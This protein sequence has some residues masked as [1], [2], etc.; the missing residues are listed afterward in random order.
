MIIPFGQWA[1]DLPIY[2]NDGLVELM[3]AK[4][5]ARSYE[6]MNDLLPTSNALDG[7]CLGMFGT[8]DEGRV[9]F[10]FAGDNAKLY[11][12]SGNTWSN[13]SQAGNYTVADDETW[14]FD[15]FGN[16]VIAV[17]WG[18]APQQFD[19]TSAALFSDLSATAPKARHVGV[20]R[21]HVV[22]GNINDAVD[23]DVPYRVHWS[24]ALDPTGVWTPDIATLA[25][26]QDLAGDGGWVQG[27]VGGEFGIVF[28]EWSVWRMS[29]AGLPV[30]W[31]FDEIE[32]RQGTPSPRSIIKY[33]N[34][35]Y[36]LGQD[37]F[38]ATDG[39]GPSQAIGDN[40]IDRFVASDLQPN[41]HAAVVGAVDPEDQMLYWAYPGADAVG[42]VP[43]RMVIYS[44]SDNKWGVADIDV[45]YLGWLRTDSQDMDT[46]INALYPNLDLMPIS[47]DSTQWGS[48]GRRIAGFGPLHTSGSFDGSPLTATFRTGA[49]SLSDSKQ[50]HLVQNFRPLVEG[51]GTIKCQIS[52]KTRVD[53]ADAFST[54]EGA[55]DEGDCPTLTPGRYF[56][57]KIT[58]EDGFDHAIGIN[59]TEAS[60]D[61]DH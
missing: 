33:R 32:K 16:L 42:G 17:V 56:S 27:I 9:A 14:S 53:E 45:E 19:I 55:D 29:L 44:I 7:R 21:D 49:H 18:E 24:P 15:K 58:A 61:G 41:A 35:A 4:P 52:G 5:A 23:G 2:K 31:Q 10:N 48:Q 1:P 30:I 6:P 28:Q 25:G 60:P 36:Y 54:A 40:R 39:G 46:D 11:Q 12:L 34:L 59:V 3:N 20:V 26:R 43:N 38:Y 50:R 47:L 8:M 57:W 22:L 37:G 13:V 51:G